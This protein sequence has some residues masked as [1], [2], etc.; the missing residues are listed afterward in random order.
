MTDADSRLAQM[1]AKL[2]ALTIE[3]GRR[4]SAQNEVERA[5]ELHQERKLYP[6][7]V[8]SMPHD[9]SAVHLLA[10]LHDPETDET[11]VQLFAGEAV[12][13]TIQ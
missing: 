3:V 8:I 2:L 5:A 13:S 4:G 10:T 9:G 12:E 6:R 11:V 7:L 1:A